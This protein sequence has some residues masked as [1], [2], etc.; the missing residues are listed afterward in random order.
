MYTLFLGDS[1]TS[2]ENN[3]NISFADYVKGNSHNLGISGTTIGEYSIYPVDGNSLLS[4]IS[5]N[6]ELI[7]NA[8]KIFI[9]YGINDV[10][11]IMCGFTTEQHVIISFVK[12]LDWIKQL[13]PNAD[14]YFLALSEDRDIIEN[15]AKLQCTYLKTD[16]FKFYD[17]IFPKSIWSTT[18]V[19]LIRALAKVVKV[20]PMI[21]EFSFE[22]H[23][24]KDNLHPNDKGYRLIAETVS[25]YI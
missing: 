23:I 17:F 12:A 16:Y 20:V 3:D 10:S 8:D 4:I 22:E 1:F 5:K 11:A 14:I 7:S 18:Y 6:T 24:D 9:E 21:T 13:N 19:S 25:E 15:F 2:G